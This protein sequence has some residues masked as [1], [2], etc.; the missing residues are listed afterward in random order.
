MMVT[1]LENFDP[2]NTHIWLETFFPITMEKHEKKT[3]QTK[4]IK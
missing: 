3:N 4:A 1:G 2:S